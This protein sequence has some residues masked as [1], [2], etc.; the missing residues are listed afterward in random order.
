MADKSDVSSKDEKPSPLPLIIVGVVIL[1]AVV[2]F[3]TKKKKVTPTPA[4][5]PVPKADPCKD[6][7]DWACGTVALLN[8]LAKA[9]VDGYTAQ[10]QAEIEK[11]RL[12][13]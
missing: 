10:Q 13:V 5:R 1:G 8:P 11:A 2:Y 6:L 9:S 12:R 4:A 3:L 7:P